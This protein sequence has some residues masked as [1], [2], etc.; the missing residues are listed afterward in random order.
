MDVTSIAASASAMSLATVQGQV[1]LS[2]LRKA[3]DIQQASALQLIQA[4]PAT[5]APAS[6]GTVGTIINTQV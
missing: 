3:L 6:T 4:L 1:G 5:P 2:V